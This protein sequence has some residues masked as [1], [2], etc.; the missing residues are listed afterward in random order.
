MNPYEDAK[1]AEIILKRDYRGLIG[2]TEIKLGKT[3]SDYYVK[4][5]WLGEKGQHPTEIKGVRVK[6]R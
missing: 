6:L 1:N 5:K 3:P 2:N 4:V